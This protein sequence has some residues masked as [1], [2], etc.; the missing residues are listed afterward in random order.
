MYDVDG[1]GYY[2]QVDVCWDA[3]TDLASQDV[4]V[5]VYYRDSGGGNG[6]LETT[7]VYTI[8]GGQSNSYSLTVSLGYQDLFDFKLELYSSSGILQD[9]LNFGEEAEITDVPLEPGIITIS[10]LFAVSEVQSGGELYFYF[11][12]ESNGIPV[13]NLALI[14]DPVPDGSLTDTISRTYQGVQG[15]V[16]VSYDLTG[17]SQDTFSVE[18]T[19]VRYQGSDL[20]FS[21]DENPVVYGVGNR[22]STVAAGVNPSFGGTFHGLHGEVDSDASIIFVSD[23]TNVYAVDLLSETK[24]GVGLEA[25]LEFRFGDFLVVKPF[26]FKAV[27]GLCYKGDVRFEELTEEQQTEFITLLVTKAGLQ[28]LSATPLMPLTLPA[29]AKIEYELWNDLYPY[30]SPMTYA[31]GGTYFEVEAGAELVLGFDGVHGGTNYKAEFDLSVFKNCIEAGLIIKTYLKSYHSGEVGFVFSTGAYYSGQVD[32]LCLGEIGLGNSTTIETELVFQNYDDYISWSTTGSPY[33][34]KIKIHITMAGEAEIDVAPVIGGC[35]NFLWPL[36]KLEG[37]PAAEIIIEGDLTPEFLSENPEVA[38]YLQS[39]VLNAG[40]LD[41]ISKALAAQK[42]YNWNYTVNKYDTY[43]L[44]GDIK[45]KVGVYGIDLGIHLYLTKGYTVE[46]GCIHSGQYFKIAEYDSEPQYLDVVNYIIDHFDMQTLINE[47]FEGFGINTYSPINVSIT[48]ESGRVLGYKDGEYVN[49]IPGAYG[50]FGSEGSYYLP[51][52][53]YYLTVYGEGNGVYTIQALNYSADE[54]RSFVIRNVDVN[55]QTGDIL[56][57]GDNFLLVPSENKVY[58]LEIE[59]R[60][61]ETLDLFTLS[62]MKAFAGDSYLYEVISWDELSSTTTN[63]VILYIDENNDGTIDITGYLHN[64][65]T[66]DDIYP[67]E[68]YWM[69]SSLLILSLYPSGIPIYYF[70]LIGVGSVT[71]IAGIAVYL[72]K[73]RKVSSGPKRWK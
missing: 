41:A 15:I 18:V 6:L 27:Y 40:I 45:L 70:A 60:T 7:S 22:L 35:L 24:A 21:M 9:T 16:A 49:E 8:Y 38:Q 52:G 13:N 50:H 57:I 61:N 65:M 42:I 73:H 39:G 26:N 17:Y 51:H 1:N 63:S 2:E 23:G 44:G 4:F 68:P 64:G 37:T 48:D 25:S 66:G 10:P 71:A 34:T 5:K 58:T 3:G 46:K 12:V 53:T 11:L 55:T 67:P 30:T 28:A 47:L 62:D 32:L 56:N 33:P 19:G 69:L 29:L 36:R 72:I 31:A 54:V 59:R 43:N 14:L 20:Q